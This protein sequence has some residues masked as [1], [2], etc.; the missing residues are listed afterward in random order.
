ML[1]YLLSEKYDVGAMY[2]Q[3]TLI[4]G[5]FVDDNGILMIYFKWLE[6]EPKPGYYLRI[7]PLK[8]RINTSY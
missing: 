7:D 6:G 5:D 8:Y 2:V 4:D 1:F 3:G